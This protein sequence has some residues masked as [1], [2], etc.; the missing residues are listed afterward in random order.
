MGK[1]Q[2]SRFSSRHL[3]QR[4]S[5]VYPSMFLLSPSRSSSSISGGMKV[6]SKSEENLQK[7]NDCMEN[8]DDDVA[9]LFMEYHQ[10]DLGRDPDLISLLNDYFS[11]SKSVSDLC[12]SLRNSLESLQRRECLTIDE[13]LLDFAAEKLR[14]GGSVSDASFRKTVA[15]LRNLDG[16]KSDRD[17]LDADF[18]R[19]T[20]ICLE[21]LAAMIAKLEKTMKRIEKKLRRVRGIR[22]IVA[23]AILAPLIA[24]IVAFKF[25]AGIFGSVPL[26]PL[27]NL[28]AWSWKKSTAS[29]KREKTA[30]TTME[31]GT[32]VALKEIEKISRLVYKLETVERSVRATADY[33]LK[34][35]S[36]VVVAMDVMETKRRRL[37]ST[38]V[39]LDKETCK[40]N[41]FANFG[42]NL[43]REKIIDFLSC[44]EISSK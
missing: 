41:E 19:R 33:A 43:A 13:A 22:G 32:M 18:L 3:R 17:F 25:V 11:T 35:R 23:A 7:L 39:D 4:I 40:C 26:D 37:E 27:T 1:N 38:M 9:K 42:R 10:T 6:R 8:M 30:V 2:R 14:Y 12:D 36:Y 31:R 44:G 16:E 21:D 20:Q 5:T 28:A 24:L 15:D 34:K 29:L